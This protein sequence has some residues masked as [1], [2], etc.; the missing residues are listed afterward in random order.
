MSLR[1]VK[2]C[3]AWCHH[4]SSFYRLASYS[5]RIQS[6]SYQW[7]SAGTM[8]RGGLLRTVAVWS[9]VSGQAELGAAVVIP[10]LVQR[11]TRSV[12][13]RGDVH[14]LQ[15][16]TISFCQFDCWDVDVIAEHELVWSVRTALRLLRLSRVLQ[17]DTACYVRCV[18]GA[19]M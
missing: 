6:V 12:E 3:A 19:Y 4:Q 17:R 18:S 15:T 8:E 10:N 14:E 1:T 13:L 7:I 5:P 11:A 2:C 9:L 16:T